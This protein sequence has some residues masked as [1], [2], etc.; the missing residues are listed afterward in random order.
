M[1]LDWLTIGAST[2]SAG[3]VGGLILL[4]VKRALKKLDDIEE[5]FHAFQLKS[6][7]EDGITAGIIKVMGNDIE[8]NKERFL[9]ILDT[10]DKFKTS[11]DR[12]SE[13]VGIPVTKFS[14][15]I[16]DLVK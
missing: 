6:V 7:K 9:R 11:L 14:D 3:L 10:Q 5:H 8:N 12:I 1:D 16:E 2:V 4:M 15:I 13:K